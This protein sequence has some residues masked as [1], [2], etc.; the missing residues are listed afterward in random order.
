MLRVPWHARGRRLE[1]TSWSSRAD[2]VREAGLSWF[3]PKKPAMY[4]IQFA[5]L[6]LPLKMGLKQL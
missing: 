1:V 6:I 2:A 5:F 4:Y 3:P